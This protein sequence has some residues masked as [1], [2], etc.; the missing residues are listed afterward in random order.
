MRE[1]C[2]DPDCNG[3]IDFDANPQDGDIA[4]CQKCGRQYEVKT[5]MWIEPVDP[6]GDNKLSTLVNHSIH[7]GTKLFELKLDKEK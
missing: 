4:A 3:Q 5:E 7:N 2:Q 6:I 1:F